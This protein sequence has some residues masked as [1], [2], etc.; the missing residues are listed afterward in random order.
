[1]SLPIARARRKN[2]PSIQRSPNSSTRSHSATES[3]NPRVVMSQ[4]VCS[5]PSSHAS[6]ISRSSESTRAKS[7]ARLVARDLAVH[8]G[9]DAAQHPGLDG[10]AEDGGEL[11]DVAGGD[12]ERCRDLAEGGP[13]TDPQLAVLAVA[14]ELV[15]VPRAARSCVQR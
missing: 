5:S 4:A 8:P 7:V 15:G 14:E 10:V 6:L 9:V 12:T 13:A 2:V 1:M 3:S 11:V